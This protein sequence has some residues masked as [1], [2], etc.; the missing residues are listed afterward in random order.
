MCLDAGQQRRS[1]TLC[2]EGPGAS[3]IADNISEQRV[4]SPDFAYQTLF[5]QEIHQTN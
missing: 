2:E 3:N 4:S 5:D 1:K